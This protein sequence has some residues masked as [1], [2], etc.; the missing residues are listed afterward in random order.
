MLQGQDCSLIDKCN[1][2]GPIFLEGVDCL[3]NWDHLLVQDPVFVLLG[4]HSTTLDD[5]RADI[6]DVMVIHWVVCIAGVGSADEEVHCKGSNPLEG[7]QVS[8]IFCQFSLQS[9]VVLRPYFV[10]NQSN[11]CRQ[12]VLSRVIGLACMFHKSLLVDL[13]GKHQRGPHSS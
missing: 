6:N 5:A 13:I 9:L 11:M 2:V 7:C 3:D 4:V 12:T 10:M 8:A 1:H